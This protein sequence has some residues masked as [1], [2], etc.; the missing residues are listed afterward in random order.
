[1]KKL[2]MILVFC[3]FIPFFSFILIAQSLDV[4]EKYSK[5]KI[6]IQDRS[7]L[8]ELQQAGLSLEGMKLEEQSVEIIMSEREIMK[9]K[10]LGF[11]Y[12][13]LIDDIS[14]YYQERSRRTE[15]EMKKLEREMKEK[16]SS[17]GF[18]FGSMGGFYTYDEVVAELDTMRMLYPS[19]ITA[20]YSIGTTLEGRTIWAV[21]ISDNPDVN[22]GEPE[23]FYNALIHAREPAGM[24]AVIYF[25][26][27]LL[28]NYGSDPEITYL[29]DNR[30]LYFVPCINVDGYEYNYQMSPNGGYMWRKNKR[31]NNGNS[32][33]EE[34]Y[35]GVDLNRNFA[36]MWGYNNI[37]SSPNP[38]DETYRGSGPFSEPETQVISDFC[39]SRNF[40]LTINFHTYSNL[41]LYSWG[42]INTPTPDN[43]WFFECS[44]NMVTFNGYLNG[45]S[46]TTLY[47]VNGS[48]DDWMYGEQ[49]TKPKIFAMTPE[50]GN[51]NDGF[52]PIPERIF[53]LA[54]EN[55]YMNKVLAWG[56]GVIDNP[57]Y[58]TEGSLNS[59][60]CLPAVDSISITA[61]E[62]NPENYNSIVTAYLYDLN[63]NLIDEFE[64]SEVSANT[65]YSSYPAPQEENFYYFLLKN[66]GIEIPSVFYYKKNLKFTTAGPLVVDSLLFLKG[67]TNY[68]NVRP[69]VKNNGSSLT[70]TN[71]KM[72]L[73]CDDPWVTSISATTLSL[74]PIAPGATV[75]GNTWIAINYDPATFPGYFNL[76]AEISRDEFIYWIDSTQLIVTGVEDGDL[77]PLT[78]NLG[79]NYP[80]PFNPTTTIVYQLP[81]SNNVTMKVY[82]VL[83][84]EV[85]VIVDKYQ[86]AGKY[87]I[88]FNAS[89]LTS[90]V[91]YYQ[92]KAGEYLNTKK[93]I[94]LK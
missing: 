17:G 3:I 89:S 60:Y 13:V 34:E 49:V 28:E 36:Y 91:Y 61:V 66:G 2:F 85:S 73:Y 18:G 9:L 55:V 27:H 40:K 68:Y 46:Y 69:F 77:R 78:Y 67:I 94:L 15:S 75:G 53:P 70:V 32:T 8:N 86:P 63:D 62:L 4:I 6:S 30:E 76:R 20:K 7:D 80:N 82:D 21:K 42:Y 79:Q 87:E 19:L 92:L 65:F 48:A 90:G 74:A 45:Q 71:A 11:S 83:G 1:M 39:N 72:R 84:N 14:K 41:L 50:V 93:M 47:E 5:V 59:S 26:Y 33:F 24:M 16:Y 51:D 43:D 10:N 25:M 52:W 64:M 57:P 37:G 38:S 88:K 81:E 35:D 23:V 29:I 44:S 12:E 56:P 22:E 31:D 58:I 54:E